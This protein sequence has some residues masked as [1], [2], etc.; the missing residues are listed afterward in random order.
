MRLNSKGAGE[1][2]RLALRERHGPPP[3]LHEGDEVDVCRGRQH[4]GVL[5]KVKAKGPTPRTAAFV[6]P[7]CGGRA[8][9][10]HEH[11]PNSWKPAAWAN[12]SASPPDSRR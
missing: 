11:R 2:S 1:P 10:H 3:P 12:E 6:Q 9:H 7:E 4:P 5:F 8:K